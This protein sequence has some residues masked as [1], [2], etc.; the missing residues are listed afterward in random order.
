MGVADTAVSC[1]ELA[2]HLSDLDAVVARMRRLVD[3]LSEEALN[4][5]ANEKRWSIAQCLDHL[6]KT[7]LLYLDDLPEVIESARREGPVGPSEIRRGPFSRLVL[8][9]TE[10]PP[11]M[12]FPAPSEVV[13]EQ[14]FA[15]DRIVA[16]YRHV[17][18]QL[19]EAMRSMDGLDLGKVKMR[20]PEFQPLKMR[21]GE[22][23]AILMSHERR[24]LWQA[25][26][27]RTAPGFP[28]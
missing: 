22:I 17:H 8:Y 25:E 9:V 7:A 26:Q 6:D 19:G 23:F 4:W 21:L 27:V 10:P 15:K 3:P 18:E 1:P 2:G 12:K 16:D 14:R 13:P 5:R 11:R 20:L 28:D 24:H